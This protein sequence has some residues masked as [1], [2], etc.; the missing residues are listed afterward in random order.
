MALQW[1]DTPPGQP[2]AGGQPQQP[3]SA[4]ANLRKGQQPDLDDKKGG[5]G[6]SKGKDAE[7]GKGGGKA[8]G[9]DKGQGKGK[10]PKPPP[11]KP[12]NA[13]QI[14]QTFYLQEGNEAREMITQTT[15]LKCF[16]DKPTVVYIPSD[17]AEAHGAAILD[18]IAGSATPWAMI[19]EEDVIPDEDLER[20][21]RDIT[22]RLEKS[23][24]TIRLIESFEDRPSEQ[25]NVMATLITQA[26]WKITKGQSATA[27]VL[28]PRDLLPVVVLWLFPSQELE[29]RERFRLFDFEN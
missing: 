16:P 18:A 3:Q 17:Y 29:K 25:R 21:I 8:K 13:V 9:K 19:T 7:K 20:K 14:I 23:T 4:W 6:H 10:R 27:T 12:P 15:P 28:P 24:P 5:K 22:V 26:M 1:E 11:P 2:P